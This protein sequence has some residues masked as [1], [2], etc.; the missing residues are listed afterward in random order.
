MA[1]YF[2][3]RAR[4]VHEE[5]L[6]KARSIRD[7]ELR[8]V[9]LSLLEN[10]VITF[11]KAEPRISFYESP[12][13][14]K[15]HHAYPG[16]L[17]DH[18]LG[19]T[20]IAEKLVE[21]YQGIYGANVDRDLVVAAALLHDLF[22]YYQYE[23]DP[24]TGGYRPRSDWYFSHDFAMVAELSVRGAP[25]KLIRAVAETHGTVP[26]TTIESQIVHQADSTDSEMVS[27]IQ[28]VIWRVCLDIELEL[29]NV[30]A[31]KIFNEAMRR[32]PI[33]EYA[34]LYYSRGRDALREHI[35]KLLGL[36]G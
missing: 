21:V 14:P 1:D 6:R 16:G 19:V 4:G 30:K 10:P 22:K 29:G 36:G 34:R 2:M 15:K 5:L 31:V 12:A 11:T 9:T 7:E 18:T 33:F 23:R 8:S 32:A 13:A 28:D 3:E 26:F 20:E 27:Q 17:L 35:K 24:L 25:E